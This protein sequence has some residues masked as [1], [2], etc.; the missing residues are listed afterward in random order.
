M[1]VLTVF[2]LIV[3]GVIL[4][5]MRVATWPLNLAV[6]FVLSLVR[7]RLFRGLL[8]AADGIHF[9]VDNLGVV[10]HVGRLLGGNGGSRPAE[11]VEDGDLILLIGWVLRLGSP[12][13]VRITKVMGH[14]DEAMV[15]DGRVRDLDRVGNSAADDAAD[16]GRRGVS[17]AVYG[18]SPQF[19][20][21][22]WQV[23]SR[24]F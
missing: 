24:F 3:D 20:W 11:L 4:M 6:A 17:V 5:M 19:W 23:V 13:T 2:A 14:A 1:I 7:C 15:R 18:C 16:F 8:Q 12:D 9:G 10:R 22:L 21:G